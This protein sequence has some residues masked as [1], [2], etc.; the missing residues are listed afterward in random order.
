MADEQ[1][2]G[3]EVRQHVREMLAR[4]VA[5]W[6]KQA[7]EQRTPDRAGTPGPAHPPDQTRPPAAS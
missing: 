4:L 1:E 2:P 7:Q 6:R 3:E 5:L